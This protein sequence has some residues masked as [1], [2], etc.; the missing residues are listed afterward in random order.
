MAPIR[1]AT[2][3]TG[4]HTSTLKMKSYY[5]YGPFKTT[6]AKNMFS[7]VTF[8]MIYGEIILKIQYK[9]LLRVLDILAKIGLLGLQA[10]ALGFPKRYHS[11]RL[12][13]QHLPI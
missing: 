1:G 7:F 10:G 9:P 2:A 11:S 13:I 5:N 4:N 6:L 12:I 3:P 8:R